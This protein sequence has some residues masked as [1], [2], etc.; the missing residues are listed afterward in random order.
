MQN[1]ISIGM[2]APN[3]TAQSTF[4]EISL[5]DFRGNWVVLFSHSDDFTPVCTSEIIEFSKA[6][7]EFQN[8]NTQLLGLSSDSNPSHL[9]WIYAIKMSSDISV[10]FPIISDKMGDIYKKYGMISPYL[11]QGEMPRNVYIIDE[12]GIIRAIM[13]Y[14]PTTGRNINEILRMIDALQTTDKSG[15]VTPANWHKNEAAMLP[16][17]ETYVELLKREE[18]IEENYCDDWYMCYSD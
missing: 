1:L 10:P 18:E 11:N 9:A 4:G 17:P 5:S 7:K 14:P 12:S 8:R 16:A 3:F 6:A 13:V 15:A 2:R